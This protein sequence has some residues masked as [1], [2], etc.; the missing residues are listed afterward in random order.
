MFFE[1]FLKDKSD[2]FRLKTVKL[3]LLRPINNKCCKID[4]QILN[5]LCIIIEFSIF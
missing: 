3:V 4:E 2:H 1:V 5:V